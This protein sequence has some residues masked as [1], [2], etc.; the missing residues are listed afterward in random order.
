MVF[1]QNRINRWEA[2]SYR[3]AG[4]WGFS[5]EAHIRTCTV[6][7]STGLRASRRAQTLQIHGVIV[8]THWPPRHWLPSLIS[9]AA[10][11]GST[12]S[13]TVSQ[14]S[15]GRD[16]NHKLMIVFIQCT[17]APINNIYTQQWNDVILT[18]AW[19]NLCRSQWQ[20]GARC[21]NRGWLNSVRSA[22]REQLARQASQRLVSVSDFNTV[23]SLSRTVASRLQTEIILKVNGG[24]QVFS[25]FQLSI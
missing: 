3:S 25:S 14:V 4:F 17:V 23:Q 21:S 1:D 7:S 9:R 2:R 22:R 12:F 5:S 24:I 8:I 10:G 11:P 6:W 20:K 16:A 13:K 18:S 15:F 19:F